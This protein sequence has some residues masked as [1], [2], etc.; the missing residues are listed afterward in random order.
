MGTGSVQEGG[1]EAGRWREECCSPA[2]AI[3][4]ADVPAA[5]ELLAILEPAVG[6]QRVTG[7]CLA[8]QRLLLTHLSR[9]ALHLLQLGP[10]GCEG[11]R[12]EVSVEVV[13][14]CQACTVG[15]GPLSWG[16]WGLGLGNHPSWCR[17]LVQINN[18]SPRVC[19]AVSVRITDGEFSFMPRMVFR[20]LYTLTD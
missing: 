9:L 1:R 20:A 15:K 4:D 2:I 12:Q 18:P 7:C 14:Q 19:D 13:R 3:L 10:S 6:G 5:V 11:T 17:F 8:L 16:R